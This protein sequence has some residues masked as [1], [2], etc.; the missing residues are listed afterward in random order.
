MEEPKSTFL[1]NADYLDSIKEDIYK[2]YQVALG[3]DVIVEIDPFYLKYKDRSIDVALDASYYKPGSEKNI[4]SNLL[5]WTRIIL[6]LT[7][8]R[9]QNHLAETFEK[10]MALAWKLL[11]MLTSA[12]TDVVEM[13]TVENIIT[14]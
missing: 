10:K 2:K 3:K 9:D 4:Y 13:G 5:G 1:Q 6:H 8:D 11:P 14:L 12:M 7:Y